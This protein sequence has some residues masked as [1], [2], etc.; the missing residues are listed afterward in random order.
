MSDGFFFLSI[1]FFLFTAWVAGG[2]P[3]KPIS[4]SGPF[5]TPITA[6]GVTQNG[7]GS[8]ADIHASI[9]NSLTEANQQLATLQRQQNKDRLYGTPSAQKGQVTLGSGNV[10]VQDPAQQYIYIRNSGSKDVTISGWR[11]VSAAT[12][13]GAT[14]PYGD[15]LPG[16]GSASPSQP[17]TLRPGDQAIVSTGSSWL[18]A[19]FLE[20]ICAGYLDRSRTF[21]PYIAPQCPYP[22]DEFARYYTGNAYKDVNCYNAVQNSNA[23]Q[24]PDV[25]ARTSAACNLFIT[26]HLTYTGCVAAHQYDPNFSTR[27]WRI[28]L[29]YHDPNA[30]NHAANDPLWLPSHEA[31][32]LLD[33]NGNTVDL[34]SY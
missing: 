23:C 1:F 8:T 17:I 20:N 33:A 24:V 30:T 14:I 25:G 12:D 7:Y 22:K 16:N 29:D 32:K 15:P 21:V 3:S 34:Y 19:S 11:I 18:G 5:I 26:Q 31:I 27:T 9:S 4:F 6:P 28:F 13:K 2:G 10:Q